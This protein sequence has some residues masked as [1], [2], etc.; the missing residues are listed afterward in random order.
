MNGLKQIKRNK[1]G[2]LINCIIGW[3]FMIII[4]FIIVLKS[5]ILWDWD[6]NW[7]VSFDNFFENKVL[8]DI[9]LKINKNETNS[10]N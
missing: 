9:G 8:K 4:S 2:K 10:K 3:I 1:M 6:W 5:I 7:D